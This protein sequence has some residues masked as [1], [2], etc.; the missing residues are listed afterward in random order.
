MASARTSSPVQ[1]I[2]KAQAEEVAETL[3]LSARF[4]SD[5]NPMRLKTLDLDDYV[6]GKFLVGWAAPRRSGNDA[7]PTFCG[8][9][10]KTGESAEP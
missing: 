5:F 10:L 8:L 2:T 4:A 3:R 6:L 9:D 7:G 1:D